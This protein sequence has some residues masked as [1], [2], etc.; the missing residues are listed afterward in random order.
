MRYQKESE[1]FAD[2]LNVMKKAFRLDGS[3]MQMCCAVMFAAAGRVADSDQLKQCRKLLHEKEGAF[4]PFRGISEAAEVCQLALSGNPE[5]T[6]DNSLT[7]YKLL[8]KELKAGRYLPLAAMLLAQQKEPYEYEETAVRAGRIYKK[9][10]QEHRMLTGTEDAAICV[11]MALSERRD[12]DLIADMEDCYEI[13]K[14]KFFY[15]NQ[16]QALSGVL[17]LY[18]EQPE[19]K[20]RHVLDLYEAIRA[21]G[22][23]YGT[24]HELATL[25]LPVTLYED[26]QEAAADIISLDAQ[27]A[28]GI[29]PV[30]AGKKHRLMFACILAACSRSARQRAFNEEDAE[31]TG[32]V[33]EEAIRQTAQVNTAISIIIAQQIV[34][35]SIVAVS[36]ASNTSH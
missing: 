36:A 10:K 21:A 7:A 3:L 9:M 25:G 28:S 18:T 2:N 19:E 27:L 22:R 12:D 16:V 34:M 8:K 13:L 24:D 33:P 23:R 29:F 32:G 35:M 4:S 30:T 14:P 5:R 15:A 11:L 17:A 20:C 6:L 26:M 31:R 1:L